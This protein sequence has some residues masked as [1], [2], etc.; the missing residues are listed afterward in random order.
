MANT[1]SH[2]KDYLV[3][4]NYT[5]YSKGFVNGTQYFGEKMLALIHEMMM[6]SNVKKE[7]DSLHELAGQVR[8]ITGRNE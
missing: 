7:L 2:W 6:N 4:D 5:D 8:K 3:D 1:L